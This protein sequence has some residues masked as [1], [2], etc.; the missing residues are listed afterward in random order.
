MWFLKARPLSSNPKSTPANRPYITDLIF[1]NSVRV[2]RDAIVLIAL[3]KSCAA[4]NTSLL[5]NLIGKSKI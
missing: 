2:V 1:L 4:T 3:S 5:I